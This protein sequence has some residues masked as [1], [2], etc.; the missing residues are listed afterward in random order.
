[1]NTD[2]GLEAVGEPLEHHIH[3][4]PVRVRPGMLQIPERKT[5]RT[6]EIKFKSFVDV[7]ITTT[8]RHDFRLFH[9]FS[10]LIIRSR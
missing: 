4:D 9:A 2:V 5:V 3:V 6:T 8:T 10:M 7:F 1:M